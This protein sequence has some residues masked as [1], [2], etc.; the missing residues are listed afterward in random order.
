MQRF[1][2]T[3]YSSG[4]CAFVTS[5]APDVA[6]AIGALVNQL[7]NPYTNENNAPA[8]KLVALSN[9]YDRP[10][11]QMRAIRSADTHATS[12]HVFRLFAAMSLYIWGRL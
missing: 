4:A 3:L 6:S 11:T 7:N 2:T 12:N 9:P 10:T 1:S 5:F 8:P